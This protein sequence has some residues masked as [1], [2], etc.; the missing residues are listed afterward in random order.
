MSV[1]KIYIGFGIFCG[2]RSPCVSSCSHVDSHVESVLLN[3]LLS[4]GTEHLIKF[5]EL[6]L[7]LEPGA[8]SWG[9]L[10][11]LVTLLAGAAPS[12]LG[13]EQQLNSH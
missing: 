2:L 3:K 1:C 10:S 4:S 7:E 9:P 8:G 11:T 13:T 12:M 5:G 6:G